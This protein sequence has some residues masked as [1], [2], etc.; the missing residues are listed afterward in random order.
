MIGSSRILNY[1][2]IY[3]KIILYN[4]VT[5]TDRIMEMK[6]RFGAAVSEKGWGPKPRQ[7]N[8]QITDFQKKEFWK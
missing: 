6:K 3:L 7:K 2:I 4:T 1:L 5:V 8:C